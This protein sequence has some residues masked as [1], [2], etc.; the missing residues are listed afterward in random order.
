M[1]EV[2]TQQLGNA[3][4]RLEESLAALRVEP[5]NLLVRDAV[6]KRFEFTF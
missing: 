3:I 2:S 4:A 6:I 1:S 5:E